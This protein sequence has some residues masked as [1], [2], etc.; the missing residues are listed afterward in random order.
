MRNAVEGG[1]QLKAR[2]FIGQAIRLLRGGASWTVSALSYLLLLA[3]SPVCSSPAATTLIGGEGDAF[4]P[5]RM[6]IESPPNST[7]AGYPIRS[8]RRSP[9]SAKL[10]L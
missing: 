3:C 7:L 2:Q 6:S 8:V 1:T 10:A 4:A 9:T 5:V